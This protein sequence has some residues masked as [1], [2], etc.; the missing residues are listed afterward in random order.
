MSYLFSIM[1]GIQILGAIDLLFDSNYFESFLC[2]VKSISSQL[3]W[4][5]KG[6]IHVILC[7]SF[8]ISS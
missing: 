3:Y 7:G 2:D 4:S 5:I 6:L 1:R 8:L